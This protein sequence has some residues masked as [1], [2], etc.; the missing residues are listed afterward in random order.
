MFKKMSIA[1]TVTIA[2]LSCSGQMS[3]SSKPM[4]YEDSVID[5]YLVNG[6][7]QHSI[8]SPEWGAYI[9][10]AIALTPRNAALWQQRAMPLFK[11]RKYELGMKYLDNAVLYDRKRYLPY[12]AFIKC[13]F[14]KT[15][16]SAI[17]D[18]KQ[19]KQ[20][21]GNTVT[22]MDHTYDFYLGLCYLQ[23]NEFDNAQCYLDSSISSRQK[24]LG[25]D[26]VHH[27]DLF[28][29]GITLYEKKEYTKCLQVFQ[30]VLNKY[31]QFSDAKYYSALANMRLGRVIEFA[32]LMSEARGD[33]KKGYTI[34][35]DNSFYE[36]Y[37]YQINKYMLEVA[38]SD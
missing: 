17:E 14:A 28:Y 20:I 2:F 16:R 37:P 36:V 10:S 31:K 33:L 35:E 18:F 23:L 29:L 27:L 25:E 22:E 32:R 12:R 34:N 8:F 13:I 24:Q 11:Q 19:A 38:N 21:N 9:D 15:Y 5:K 26:W 3:N 7:W 30:K 4:S 6:A 1:I